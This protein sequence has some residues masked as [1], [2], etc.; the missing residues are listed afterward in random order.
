[1]SPSS[2]LVSAIQRGVLLLCTSLSAPAQ[3]L[4]GVI[5]G[6]HPVDRIFD[7]VPIE[8][9][10][11]DGYGEF[12]VLAL[13]GPA[14]PAG[15]PYDSADLHWFDGRTLQHT[16]LS[17]PGDPFAGPG[18]AAASAGDFDG[19]GVTDILWHHLGDCFCGGYGGYADVHSGASG[20]HLVRFLDPGFTTWG[21]VL[22]GLGDVDQDGFDDVAVASHSAGTVYVY[23][24]PTGHLIRVHYG[25]GAINN[26]VASLGDIDFDGVPDYAVGGATSSTVRIYSG[27][28]GAFLRVDSRAPLSGFGRSIASVGDLDGDGVPDYA[29]GAPGS[30]IFAVPESGV[31]VVSGATG[32]DLAYL[33]YPY[34]NYQEFGARIHAAHDIN[35]DGYRDLVVGSSVPYDYN[36]VYSLRT[37]SLLWRVRS[38]DFPVV[39]PPLGAVQFDAPRILGDLDGDG[40]A[41]WAVI[42][43]RAD[44]SWFNSGRIWIFRG[45]MTDADRFCAAQPNSL[46][47][48]ATLRFEGP[49]TVGHPDQRVVVEDAV[50]ASFAQ[51]FYGVAQTGIVFGDGLLC[52]GGS[53]YRLG[54]PFSLDATGRGARS[55]DWTA[56]P[57]T[58]GPGAWV[59]G[60]AFA[61]QVLYRD[62]GPGSS[63]G[64]NTTDAL[65][66]VFND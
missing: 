58:A 12:I 14:F 51:L 57:Q 29:A 35:G 59:A 16:G 30:A 21:Q 5:D 45:A 3:S 42:D 54:A 37:F 13:S 33:P 4:Y 49:L 15:N 9:L 39:N 36:H 28:T 11:G 47:R 46:G 52:A 61:L 24:G 20:A 40:R 7:I 2:R 50:P 55:I 43:A 1:M 53:L 31:H 25:A 32:E 10:N 65:R 66:I 23:G 27:A 18:Y 17:V 62:S 64:F 60:R 38:E 48:Q 34:G 26:A 8:D 41:E 22:A 56:G 44:H 63:A 6:L 19:D